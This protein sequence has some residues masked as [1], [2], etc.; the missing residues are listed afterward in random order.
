MANAG[1]GLLREAPAATVHE[2]E[3]CP[4]VP[5]SGGGPAAPVECAP[6]APCGQVF[7]NTSPRL[8]LN[9]DNAAATALPQRL[10]LSCLDEIPSA[11]HR[12]DRRWVRRVVFNLLAQSADGRLDTVRFRRCSPAPDRRQQLGSRDDTPCAPGQSQQDSILVGGE[13]NPHRALGNRMCC[14]VDRQ[15]PDPPGPGLVFAGLPSDQCAHSGEQFPGGATPCSDR[16]G[17]GINAGR[18]RG[19]IP[20]WGQGEQIRRIAALPEL[21]DHSCGRRLGTVHITDENGSR[22][23]PIHVSVGLI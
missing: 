8:C 6:D 10:S 14:G 16:I 11:A 13:R 23:R 17:A 2:S 19:H 22:A 4:L 12:N 3:P 9:S 18:Q 1:L 15:A 21:S 7:L 5:V 20:R